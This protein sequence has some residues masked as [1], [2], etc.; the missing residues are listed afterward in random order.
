MVKCPKCIV[1][2]AVPGCE[3]AIRLAEIEVHNTDS[4]EKYLE[5]YEI[6]WQK[7]AWSV[8]EVRVFHLMVIK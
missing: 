6:D 5:L 1:Q 3:V 8:N 4:T 2:C 7:K